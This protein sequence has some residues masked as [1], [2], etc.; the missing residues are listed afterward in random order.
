MTS[1]AN[2][3]N[4][5]HHRSL[6]R[7]GRFMAV[8]L[9]VPAGAGSADSE[10]TS[11]SK[12][13]PS[14]T[15]T[16]S[17][18]PSASTASPSTSTL[19][20]SEIIIEEL[21]AELEALDS[22][23]AKAGGAPASTFPSEAAPI[24]L[25]HPWHQW[26]ADALAALPRQYRTPAPWRDTSDLLRLCYVH[27]SLKE[28]GPTFTLNLN[29]NPATERLAKLQPDSAR[30]LH[31]RLARRLEQALGRRVDLW[32]VLEDIH[33]LGPRHRRLH[34]HGAMGIT[35]DEAKE[36]RA[37]LR[38]AGGEW[39]TV[40]QH[41]SHTAGDPDYGW[42]GYCTKGLVWHSPAVERLLDRAGDHRRR[43]T[44]NG[45]SWAASADIRDRA[46]SL[47]DEDRA[48][49]PRLPS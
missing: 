36:A 40:R 8:L 23:S 9:G 30:W 31:K 15:S 4:R 10:E 19:S 32:F 39:K 43:K 24:W 27:R 37:A 16:T 48:K 47:Y 25:C 20:A 5:K 17:S 45:P 34:L 29:L 38:K 11:V 14:S 35:A 26:P 42:L 21:K 49:V 28:A 2:L 3:G 18:T 46:R 7:D 41:Q 6:V 22:T 33:D 13:P 44:F 1:F 12:T